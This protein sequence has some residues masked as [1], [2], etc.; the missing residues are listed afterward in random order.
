MA[1]WVTTNRK[2]HGHGVA[3]ELCRPRRG[4]IS[5]GGNRDHAHGNKFTRKG[6]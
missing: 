3:R 1:N 5:C 6:R 4:D 2:H